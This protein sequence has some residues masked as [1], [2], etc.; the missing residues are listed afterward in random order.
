M[1]NPKD[2][3]FNQQKIREIA[4]AFQISRILLTAIELDI[5]SNLDKHLLTAEDLAAKIN[6]DVKATERLLNALVAIGFINK[7]KNKFYNT[8]ETSKYLVKGKPEFMAGLFHTNELWKSW[9]T[10]TNT[11]KVGKSVF[12]KEERNDDWAETFIAAMHYRAIKESKILVSM[13]NLDHINSMLDIGGGSGIFSMAFVEKNN[14]IIATI[15]DLPNII[16]ITKKY[17]DS[18]LLKNKIKFIEGDYLKD[19]FSGCYDLIFL[20]SIIHI[21]SFEQNK[22]LVKKCYDSLNENGQIIIKDWIMNDDKTEPMGGAIF[23][24]NMLVATECG[25]TYSESEIK[26]WFS[27]CGI[28]RIEKKN[29]KFR[30]EFINWIQIMNKKFFL[31]LVL[32][33]TIVSCTKKKEISELLNGNFSQNIISFEEKPVKLI[34]SKTDI[35]ILILLHNRFSD[36]EIKSHLKFSDSLWNYKIN[37][38]FGNGLI[39]KKENGSFLPTIFILDKDNS[40]ELKKFTD[41]LGAELSLITIDRLEKIKA[42]AAKINSF[43]NIPF[44]N[45]SFFALGSVIHDCWQLKFYQDEFL[46]SFIPSRGTSN[47]YFALF[48]NDNLYGQTFRIY[49]TYFY[50]YPNYQFVTF[51]LSDFDYNIPTFPT[52]ELNKSFGKDPQVGDSVFQIKLINELIKLWRSH[53]YKPEKRIEEGFEKY[54]LVKN[55]KTLVPVLSKN[56]K[57]QLY[58]IAEV[59][60]PDLISYFEN[61][62]TLF[63]KKYLE[64][65][66][67]DETSYKEWMAWIYKMITAKSIDKLIEKGIIKQGITSPSIIIEKF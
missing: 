55:G 50:D 39:K 47:F 30:M 64:S 42:S 3:I 59:I 7:I 63:V 21:N 14:N 52:S 27:N 41:S 38:L 24:L 11:I 19:D 36:E 37:Y 60:K 5:F 28:N 18:F 16:P 61:R 1:K 33:I 48:Q 66:F 44:E 17:V 9:S 2:E 31:V 43:K 65:Q 25:D 57:I 29:N 4:N 62:Q 67:R 26:Q 46:K 13:L 15:F 40:K 49:H 22:L 6:C 45:I 8:D 10:L 12:K 34:L 53:N 51:G 23:S 58:K 20:S 35:D 54:G 32:L 56:E